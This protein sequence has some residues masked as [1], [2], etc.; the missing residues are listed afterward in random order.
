MLF[1]RI[2]KLQPEYAMKEQLLAKDLGVTFTIINTITQ[3]QTE[4]QA[5]WGS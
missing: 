5:Y 2:D 4:R 3:S 1:P